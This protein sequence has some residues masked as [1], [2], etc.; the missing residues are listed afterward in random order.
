M[1]RPFSTPLF[2][3]VMVLALVA[4]AAFL[5]ADAWLRPLRTAERELAGGDVAG[6]LRDF[7]VAE[8]R[9]DRAPATKQVLPAAYEASITNQ[10]WVLYQTEDYD[11]LIEKAATSPASHGVRFWAGCALFQKGRVEE[12]AEARLGWLG[13]AEEE[14]RKA[15]ELSPDDWDT[16][17]D[18]ELTKKLLQELK[19]NPK[20]PPKQLIQLLRPQPKAGGQPAK[21]V[22]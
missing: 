18:Y 20:T 21:R 1:R 16:K 6:A 22:G 11:A 12:Q 3:F 17:F 2:W 7:G 9:F 8:A 10:L 13:R 15:L 5:A 4:G 14:F 19:K